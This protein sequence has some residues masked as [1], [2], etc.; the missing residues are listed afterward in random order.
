LNLH[1]SATIP[2]GLESS[3]S[4]LQWE[5]AGEQR[6]QVNATLVDERDSQAEKFRD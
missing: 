2:G 6:L 1:R 5:R 3:D 4:V